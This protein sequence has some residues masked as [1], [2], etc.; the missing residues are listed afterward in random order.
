MSFDD[1]I[2]I[3]ADKLHRSLQRILHFEGQSHNVDFLISSLTE[4]NPFYFTDELLIW[5]NDFNKLAS[6]EV[7]IIPLIEMR[8]WSFNENTG[9][10]CHQSGEYFSIRGLNVKTNTGPVT[11]WSQ[12][13]IDQPE[14]GVLGIITQKIDGILY[15]YMQAKAEPGNINTYQISPTVQTTRSNFTQQH[16]GKATPYLEYF[17]NSSRAEVLNDQLQSERGGRF[18]RR[19]NRN[20]I[21]RIPDDEPIKERSEFRWFTLG[22]LK[23]IMLFND[24][25]NMDSRSVLSSIS[26]SPEKCNSMKPVIMSDFRDCVNSFKYIEKNLTD[27]N[28]KVYRSSFRSTN[29][30][31]SEDEILRVMSRE[32][33]RCQLET[34]TI[35]LKEIKNWHIG[36]DCIYH[37]HGK[38]FTIIGVRIQ[39][40]NREISSWDQPIIRQHDPG[41]V[42]MICR[43]FDG[44]LHFLIQL[45]AEIGY[46]DIIE[47][48]PTVQC[49]TGS[50][51]SQQKPPFLM[52]MLYPVNYEAVFDTM[53]SEGG[54]WFYKESN[55]NT[56]YYSE[57]D[58]PSQIPDNYLWITLN[59]MKQLLKFNN[60]INVEARSILAII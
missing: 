60:L 20:I 5:L 45:K 19:R 41:I 11:Q 36:S 28:Q 49:I 29:G 15:F 4:Y 54:G 55:R 43:E 8:N 1:N 10:L 3:Q 32:R 6:F 58:H 24:R 16:S 59:Q 34:E 12:P 50:D 17:T 56:L 18:L 47:M 42:G 9:D 40:D 30:I 35:P 22:Q 46:V 57:G 51:K 44:L 2:K 26:F 27:F 48:S 39:T 25:I 33:F 52:E 31:S 7:S 21:V 38:Y 13:I 53:Q 23:H 37:G 14:I